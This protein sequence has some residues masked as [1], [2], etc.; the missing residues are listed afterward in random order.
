MHKTI[1]IAILNQK[2][3]VGKTTLTN[4]LGMAFKNLGLNVLLVDGDP[5]GSLRDWNDANKASLLPVIGLD[6]ETLPQDLKAV[7]DQYDIVLI[8]GA[9]QSTK[10]AGAGV[11]SADIVIIPTT[12][13]PY[14][15][16]ASAD[17]VEIVKARQEV[18]DGK[19]LA[20][21][22]ISKVRKNTKLGN[23]IYSAIDEYDL[24]TLDGRTTDLEV[25]KQT[26]S[27]GETVFQ[28]KDA[29]NAIEEITEIA[30]K[31]LG[32]LDA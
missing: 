30:N 16:W 12:P 26:A 18:T 13:S 25:Y 31:I 23:E 9:P 10:L 3:G 20:Y 7:K 1:T 4:N 28:D 5:Q 15:V 24:P 2:G 32:V 22:L 11:K 6:R 17:L 29:K 21:F 27:K 19:P 8:D 14:D